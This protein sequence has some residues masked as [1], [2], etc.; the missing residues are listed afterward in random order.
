V[1]WFTP[2]NGEFNES[3]TIKAANKLSFTSPFGATGALL[4]LKTEN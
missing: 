4:Y 2:D 3:E 1:E